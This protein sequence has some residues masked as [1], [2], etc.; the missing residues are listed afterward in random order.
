MMR[1]GGAGCEEEE[2]KAKAYFHGAHFSKIFQ[3]RQRESKILRLGV[4]LKL[5]ALVKDAGR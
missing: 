2:T 3:T 4:G 1:D 5:S